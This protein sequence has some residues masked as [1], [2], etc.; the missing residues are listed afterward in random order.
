[1]TELQAHS[2]VSDG[3]LA[4]RA[5]V[6]AAAS[7]GVTVLALTD[8]D[9]VDG[10]R[11]AAAAAADAGTQ[12]VAAVELSS[13]FGGHEDPR[14]CGYGIDMARIEPACARAREE[15]VAR[16]RA[17]VE[18]LQAAGVD[19]T[20]E[21]AVAAAGDGTSIGRPH[22]A[23]ATGAVDLND[24]FARYLVPGAPT[25]VGRSWPTAEAAIEIIR[26]AGGV[27]VLAHP[28]WDLDDPAE[29]ESLIEAIR[30]DGVECFYPT[31]N[32]DQTAFLVRLCRERGLLRTASSDYHGPSHKL[33]NR[34]GAYDAFGLGAPQ[35]PS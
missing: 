28:F 11:E 14:I 26:D 25:F 16:A 8:H 18:R 4:P 9:A 10:V 13:V 33:F 22:I 17:I 7:A 23:R 21:R 29:V 27:A 34:F 32:R 5:V 30:P 19:V 2:T 20:F 35:V 12:L 6:E 31:H 3:E 24:F 15:R 1:M